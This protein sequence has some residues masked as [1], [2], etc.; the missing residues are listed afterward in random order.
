MLPF[1]YIIRKHVPE[2]NA[3]KLK[4]T[5]LIENIVFDQTIAIFWEGIILIEDFN[6]LTSRILGL[7]SQNKE[8]STILIFSANLV[9]S[10]LNNFR[11][12]QLRNNIVF[13]SKSEESTFKLAQFHIIS[14]CGASICHGNEFMCEALG[15][16]SKSSLHIEV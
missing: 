8:L 2:F 12:L 1:S 3:Y 7:K 5:F 15:I 6:N 9:E 10:S 11:L 14:Q 13:H 4:E 16:V